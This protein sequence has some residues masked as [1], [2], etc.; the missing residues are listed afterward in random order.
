MTTRRLLPL[1]V[2]FVLVAAC[3]KDS[4]GYDGP[5]PAEPFTGAPVAFEVVNVRPPKGLDVR[6]YNFSDKTFATYNILLRYYDK[7][8]KVLLVDPGTQFEE[9][10]GTWFM[11]GRKYLSK[12]KQWTSFDIRADVPA[13]T[14]KAEILASSVI[15]LNPDGV[16][17]ESDP[18]WEVGF[19]F[20]LGW[21]T[22]P[23]TE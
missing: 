12:P 21:P 22:P 2:L 23:A 9:D 18:T 8:G 13:G 17:V 16:T 1:A 15:A 5:P 7:D 14:V 6:V 19:D 11:L 3:D 4:N 20:G 10:H